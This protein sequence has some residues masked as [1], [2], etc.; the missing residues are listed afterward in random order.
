MSS[1]KSADEEGYQAEFF[2]HGL[3]TLASY[4]VDLFNHAVHEG[5]PPVWAHHILYLIH[6]SGST[7]DPNDYRMIMVGHTFSKL[8]AIFL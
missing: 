1:S 2:K 5:F 8:Y 6:K 3:C 7:S 4:L